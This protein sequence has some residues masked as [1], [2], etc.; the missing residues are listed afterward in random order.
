MFFKTAAAINDVEVF[1]FFI[2]GYSTVRRQCCFKFSPIVNDRLQNK[3]DRISL[4]LIVVLF[5]LSAVVLF[6]GCRT[7]FGEFTVDALKTLGR[8]G[9]GDGYRTRYILG[10]DEG[11]QLLGLSAFYFGG[12]ENR[13]TA[14][15]KE[16]GDDDGLKFFL[17]IISM[18]RKSG[19]VRILNKF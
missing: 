12:P 13:F 19:I 9:T 17:V 2:G 10:S 18:V 3:L 14:F 6:N 4:T 16:I 11:I 7:F 5:H 8:V 15:E 1:C